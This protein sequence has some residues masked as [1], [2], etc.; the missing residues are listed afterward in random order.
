MGKVAFQWA[1]LQVAA[2]AKPCGGR[3]LGRAESTRRMSTGGGSLG[4]KARSDHVYRDPSCRHGVGCPP[5][6]NLPSF[7]SRIQ[8]RSAAGE[9]F[10]ASLAAL[11]EMILTPNAGTFLKAGNSPASRHRLT[12]KTP[13]ASRILCEKYTPC[14][15]EANPRLDWFL[16][17][18]AWVRPTSI[19]FRAGI[20]CESK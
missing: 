12:Q 15:S 10:L 1:H 3:T 2:R 17:C 7:P 19:G 6:L 11:R 5:M 4:A 8:S 9:I 13:L 14:R 18:V 20:S 16:T